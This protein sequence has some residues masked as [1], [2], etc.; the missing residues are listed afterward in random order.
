MSITFLTAKEPCGKT[1]IFAKSFGGVLLPGIVLENGKIYPTSKKPEKMI[2]ETDLDAALEIL[3]E[4]TQDQ[5][6][7]VLE[8]VINI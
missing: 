1:H 4:H 8:S 5:A 2:P 7:S 3:P 6:R